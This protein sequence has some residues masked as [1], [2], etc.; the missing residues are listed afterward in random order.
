MAD[1][2]LDIEAAKE[3]GVSYIWLKEHGH[4]KDRNLALSKMAAERRGQKIAERRRKQESDRKQ[5]NKGR[6]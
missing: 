2:I 5:A 6:Y 3:L 1:E 4:V